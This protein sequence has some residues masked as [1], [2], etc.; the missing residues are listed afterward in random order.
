MA[1]SSIAVLLN[2][3]LLRTSYS[4][5]VQPRDSSK[6]GESR[7]LSGSGPLGSANI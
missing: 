7:Q 6:G 3:L 2:S 4:G 1:F 5:P